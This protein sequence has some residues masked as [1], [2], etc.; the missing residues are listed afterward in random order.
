MVHSPKAPR[1]QVMSPPLIHIT[2]VNV[3][4]MSMPKRTPPPVMVNGTSG[5]GSNSSGQKE[6]AIKVHIPSTSG[7]GPG[8]K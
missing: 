8:S 3:P 7:I 5:E 4:M 1:D 6:I 2:D